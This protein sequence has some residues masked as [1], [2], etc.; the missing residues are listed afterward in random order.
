[1][2][3]MPSEK[4]ESPDM[5]VSAIPSQSSCGGMEKHSFDSARRRALRGLGSVAVLAASG[6]CE[7]RLYPIDLLDDRTHL[8]ACA[9]ETWKRH[10][11]EE[12]RSHSTF[13][14]ARDVDVSS[15]CSARQRWL[16]A[17]VDVVAEPAHPHRRIGVQ[18][19]RRMLAMQGKR[20]FRDRD[21]ACTLIAW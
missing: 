14:H 2:R 10:Q 3:S 17:R 8:T 16:V 18:I 15:E 6:C 9:R 5:S 19:D 12:L 1:M 21:H 13:A 7:F 20:F 11:A 4:P